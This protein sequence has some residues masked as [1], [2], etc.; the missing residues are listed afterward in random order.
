[1]HNNAGARALILGDIPAARVHLEQAAHTARAIGMASETA[2]G[3]L[4]W[5][6]REEGDLDGARSMFED[7]LRMSRRSGRQPAMGYAILGL[8][9]LATDLGN[10]DRAAVLHGTAQAFLDRSGR[11]WDDPEARYR[12]D[13]L[14]Q[15]R[16]HLGEE[17]FDRAYGKGMTL[18]ADEA[19]RSALGQSPQ[20]GPPIAT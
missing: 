20:P 13:S 11:P 16:A 15:V 14:A 10:W 9:C 17:R 6:R 19:L 1:M 8:A 12:Q 18:P 3:N 2:A 4:G 5:V 7:S